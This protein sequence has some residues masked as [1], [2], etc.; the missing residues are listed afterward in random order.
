MHHAAM[1]CRNVNKQSWRRI[2]YAVTQQR[3]EIA[4]HALLVI[5]V[6]ETLLSCVRNELLAMI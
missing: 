5:K 6:P 3:T 2:V 1:L 4:C